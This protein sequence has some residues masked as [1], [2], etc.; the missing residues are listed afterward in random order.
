MYD[1]VII[2]KSDNEWE[3]NTIIERGPP[4]R[5]RTLS[6]DQLP[7]GDIITITVYIIRTHHTRPFFF[8]VLSFRLTQE[9]LV[10]LLYTRVF[11]RYNSAPTTKNI[12]V[13][14]LVR[15]SEYVTRFQPQPYKS[16]PKSA[17]FLVRKRR[18]LRQRNERNPN[19]DVFGRLQQK[20]VC[21]TWS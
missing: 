9:S 7:Y 2:T 19:T 4:R 3:K 14:N 13:E 10:F 21:F 20:S 16:P 15:P 8:S 1:C 6:K 17:M 11:L 5:D 12:G 18:R